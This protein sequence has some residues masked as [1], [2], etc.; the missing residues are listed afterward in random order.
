[1]KKH[2]QCSRIGEFGKW[3]ATMLMVLL[4][5]SACDQYPYDDKEPEWLGS[6]IYE[7]LKSDGNYSNYTRM[8]EDLGYIEVLSTTGSKTLFVAN[9][10]AFEEFYNS[11]PWG[12]KSYEEL[13]RAQKS[14]LLNFSMINNAYLIEMLANYNNNGM[15]EGAAMRRV[16]AVSVLDSVPFARPES[17]PASS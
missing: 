13:T 7:Y 11:N 12:V 15:K 3:L 5:F 1:M 6:S 17:L 9:D 14:L 8:I 10:S 16:T 2:F 4:T